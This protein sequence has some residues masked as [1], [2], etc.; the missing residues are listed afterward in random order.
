MS[1]KEMI[2]NGEDV[3]LDGGVIVLNGVSVAEKEEKEKQDSK[4]ETEQPVVAESATEE[5][6]KKAEENE[7]PIETTKEP[8]E[9]EVPQETP[10]E[11]P[12]P[13]ETPQIPT[14]PIDLTGILNSDATQSPAQEVPSYPQFPSSNEPEI[15]NQA[16]EKPNNIYNFPS[17]M[18]RD[19]N[20]SMF[21]GFA[22]P[23]DDELS[24]PDGVKKAVEMVK[25]EVGEI[26]KENRNL[27]TKNDE[28]SQ[29]NASL[30]SDLSKKDAEIVILKDKISNIQSSMATAQARI[31]DVFGMGAMGPIKQANFDD[32][33]INNGGMGMAA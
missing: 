31:L 21:G 1:K 26:V 30:K 10:V 14:V 5:S 9:K 4:A 7:V 17:S 29:E 23:T 33:Q 16:E 20:S 6:E 8:A 15:P 24:M 12:V 13:E 18:D 2:K 19:F 11:I 22:A 3:S 25:N 28:L 32:D 27:R